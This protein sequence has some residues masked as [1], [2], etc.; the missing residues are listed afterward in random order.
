M[1]V[2]LV[3]KSNVCLTSSSDVGQLL[4]FGWNKQNKTGEMCGQTLI[5]ASLKT[6]QIYFI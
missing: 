6:N 2:G 4:N 3:S 1:K 5:T